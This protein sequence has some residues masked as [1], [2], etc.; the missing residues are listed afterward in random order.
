MNS[1]ILRTAIRLLV[2]LQ[3][4]FAL[5]LLWRGHNDPGGGFVG[6]LVVAAAFALYAVAHGAEQTQ[7]LLRLEPMTLIGLGLL[8]AVLSGLAGLT[9]GEFLTGLWLHLGGLHFGTPQLFDVGVFLTVAG[10]AL[11]ILF[12]LME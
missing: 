8:V 7:R 6:G 5:F 4:V 2:P 10:V 3:V 11:K 1:L 12:T 9:E